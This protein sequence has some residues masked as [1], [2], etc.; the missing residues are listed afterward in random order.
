[1]NDIHCSRA[2]A[3]QILAIYNESIANSTALW[4]YEPRTM[5][6]M[7]AF[8]EAKE[9]GKF[10]V[11]GVAD[12]A[13]TLLAFGTYGPF[14]ERP[15][16][17]YTIEHSLY[18]EK[19]SRG[20]GLGRRV[21]IR[22]IAAAEAQGYHTIVGGIEAKNTASIGLHT[23]LGFEPCGVIRQSGFK[24]GQWLDLAFYQLVLNTPAQ[25]VDGN[26]PPR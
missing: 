16:Y 20:K 2:H 21:L 22:L 7:A 19:G 8:F 5:A 4:D 18:V 24:F 25:P 3:A 6:A 26:A 9:R 13:G 23:S 10:P 12:E 17:K 11:L 15:A 1:M 14:R